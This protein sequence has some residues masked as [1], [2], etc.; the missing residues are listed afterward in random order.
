MMGYALLTMI[1]LKPLSKFSYNI[2]NGWI[3]AFNR[4]DVTTGLVQYYLFEAEV[5][6]HGCVYLVS[7]DIGEVG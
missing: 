3:E 7:E 2:T 6:F 1:G 5:K 4:Q